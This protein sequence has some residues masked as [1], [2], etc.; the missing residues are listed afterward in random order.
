MKKKRP[1]FCANLGMQL[2]NGAQERAP[3]RYL[4]LY[5]SFMIIFA[6][7]IQEK[8]YTKTEMKQ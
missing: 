8:M 5:W 2:Q 7:I 4:S 6:T 3:L 1:Q